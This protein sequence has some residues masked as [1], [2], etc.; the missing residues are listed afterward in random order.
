MKN[1]KEALK[2]AKAA[3]MNITLSV[4]VESYTNLKLLAALEGISMSKY[5]ENHIEKQTK[6]NE[7]KL[8]SLFESA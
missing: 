3:K 7:K 8:N 6:I 2:K 4:E 5:I 1:I